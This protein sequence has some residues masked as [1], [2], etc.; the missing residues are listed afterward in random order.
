MDGVLISSIGGVV[1]CWRRWAQMYSIPNWENY[2]IPHGTRAIDVIRQLRPDL[3]EAG[4]HEGLRII[5]DLEIDDTSDL[6]VL[7][8]VRNLL[9]SLPPERWSIVTSATRRLLLARL[10]VAKL[11]VPDR[12]IAGDEVINGKPHPEPYM[13]GAK[14]LGLTPADCIVVEDA[15]AGVG[16]GLAAGSRVLGVLGTH[17][18]E[19]LSACSWIVPSLTDVTARPTPDGLELEF[20]PI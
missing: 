19:Q 3:D 17:T 2:Q 14:L 12:V 10:R 20:E 4:V 6:E 7:P 8:G 9:A 1:R 11:P 13:T 15:P 5:E 18:A 16:A